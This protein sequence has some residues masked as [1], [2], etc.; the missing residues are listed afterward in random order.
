MQKGKHVC[1]RVLLFVDLLWIMLTFIQLT[2][3]PICI[4]YLYVSVVC[5]CLKSVPTK[6][7]CIDEIG[8][9]KR[10]GINCVKMLS[11]MHIYDN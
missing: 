9:F 4:S 3:F 6:D 2:E 11:V 8:D 5:T 1:R 7:K 10:G